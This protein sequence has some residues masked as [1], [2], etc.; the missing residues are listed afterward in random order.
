MFIPRTRRIS[1]EAK[2]RQ[3]VTKTSIFGVGVVYC[4]GELTTGAGRGRASSR[5][6]AVTT[7]AGM[8]FP[9]YDAV[10]SI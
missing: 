8:R 6:F 9:F 4:G 10:E 1:G 7:R 2:D 5:S 3:F